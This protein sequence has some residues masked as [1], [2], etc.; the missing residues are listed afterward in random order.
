M[1]EAINY[2]RRGGKLMVYGVYDNAARVHWSPYKIFQDEIQVRMLPLA[3]QALLCSTHIV[4]LM[5]DEPLRQIIGSFA[6]THCFPRAV[7]YLDSGKVRV[8]GMVRPI[9]FCAVCSY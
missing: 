1:N 7:Q 8:K 6:Q 2:V 3:L 5:A 9:A 4:C